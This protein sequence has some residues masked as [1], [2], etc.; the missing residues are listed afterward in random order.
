MHYSGHDDGHPAS[1]TPNV[2]IINHSTVMAESPEQ[3]KEES[4]HHRQPDLT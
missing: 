3:L 2:N 4:N 1:G